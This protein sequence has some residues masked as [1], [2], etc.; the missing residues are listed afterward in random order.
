MTFS[1]GHVRDFRLPLFLIETCQAALQ[2]HLH[3]RFVLSMSSNIVSGSCL[4]WPRVVQVLK[5]D[6]WKRSLLSTQGRRCSSEDACKVIEADVSAGCSHSPF[7]IRFRFQ[8]GSIETFLPAFGYQ[9]FH[10]IRSVP[11]FASTL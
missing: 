7:T 1:C 10:I 6:V 4:V 11:T 5:R 2:S 8:F 3:V 9:S